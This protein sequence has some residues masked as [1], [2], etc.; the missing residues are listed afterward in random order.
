MLKAWSVTVGTEAPTPFTKADVSKTVSI[1]GDAVTID[2]VSRMVFWGNATHHDCSGTIESVEEKQNGRVQLEDGQEFQ[3]GVPACTPLK[4]SQ[5]QGTFTVRCAPAFYADPKD[6]HSCK[7]KDMNSVCESASIWMD[8][9]PVS[10]ETSLV[11]G[12]S[13]TMT[14]DVQTSGDG[15]YKVRTVPLQVIACATAVSVNISMLCGIFDALCR[16][17]KSMSFRKAGRR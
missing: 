8:D 5:A 1:K 4:W 12:E 6:G 2:G 7:R 15:A 10:D 3:N 16:M 11:I 9:K 14:L 13:S 17:R